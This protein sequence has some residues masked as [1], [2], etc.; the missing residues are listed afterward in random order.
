MIREG[1]NNF[2]TLTNPY[3]WRILS[4]FYNKLHMLVTQIEK[5]LIGLCE[6]DQ[7][8]SSTWQLHLQLSFT[9][10]KRFIATSVLMFVSLYCKKG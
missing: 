5:N 4:T 3:I 7:L 2:S 10:T 6:R 9:F 1:R 8:L